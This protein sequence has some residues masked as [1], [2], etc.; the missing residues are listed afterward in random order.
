MTLNGL[1]GCMQ[2]RAPHRIKTGQYKM[3]GRYVAREG[4]LPEAFVAAQGI[5]EFGKRKL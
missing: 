4:D 5:A 2:G 1:L 3:I